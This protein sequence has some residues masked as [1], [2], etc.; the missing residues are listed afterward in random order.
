MEDK[1][2]LIKGQSKLDKITIPFSIR[3]ARVVFLSVPAV[4]L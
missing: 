2:P 3:I 4:D 1:L